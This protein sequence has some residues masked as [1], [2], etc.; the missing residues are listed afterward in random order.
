MTLCA[1]ENGRIAAKVPVV[2][3]I[4]YRHSMVCVTTH[5]LS[6]EPPDTSCSNLIPVVDIER[7]L[8]NIPSSEAA[9]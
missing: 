3:A 8:E 2:S 6:Y 4:G 5:K 1:T 9:Q 7:V